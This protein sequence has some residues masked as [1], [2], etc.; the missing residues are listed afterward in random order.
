MEWLLHADFEQLIH[1]F[2]CKTQLP[3]QLIN[4]LIDNLI[5]RPLF[6]IQLIFI[7]PHLATPHF[8]DPGFEVIDHRLMGIDS[9]DQYL[10]FER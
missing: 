10:L 8:A 6:K 1:F 4:I 2:H 5:K 7:Y 3:R 9:T